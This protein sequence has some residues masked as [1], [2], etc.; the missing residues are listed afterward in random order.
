MSRFKKLSHVLWRCQ[1]HNVWVMA[2]KT[3]FIVYLDCHFCSQ[4]ALRCEDNHSLSR[5]SSSCA[6]LSNLSLG[7][8]NYKNL[9][10]IRTMDIN[11]QAGLAFFQPPGVSCRPNPAGFQKTPK[12]DGHRSLIAHFQIT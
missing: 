6:Q 12:T 8:Y 1:Y 10:N 11:D 3:Q 9:G 2:T 7:V 5:S 4:I